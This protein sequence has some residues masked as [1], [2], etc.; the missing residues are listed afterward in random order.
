MFIEKFLNNGVPYLRLVENYRTTDSNGVKRVRKKTILN[1]GSLSKFDDGQPNFYERLKTSFKAGNPLI[2]VLKPYCPTSPV[3]ERYNLTFIEG[4]SYCF[5][6]PKLYS[7]CLI[8]QYLNALG[9]ISTIA[10]CKKQTNIQFD[11]AGFVRLLIYGRILKP[12]SKIGTARQNNDYYNEIVKDMYEYNIYDT[13][14]FISSYK[15]KF[16]RTLNKNLKEKFNRTT[17]LIYYDVTNFYF[18][19]ERP[20]EDYEDEDGDINVGLRKN[21]VSKEERKLPIVQ[22]GLF[23]DEQG[24]PIS[25]ETFPGNTLD[26]LTVIK[27]LEKSVDDLGLPRFI[28]VGDRGM[29][30]G[31]NAAYLSQHNN[32]YIMSK[33]IQKSSK[34][35]KDWMLDQNGFTFIG[36]DFKY[37]SRIVQRKVK[38]EDGTYTISE[39]MIVYWSK[40]FY[41][42]MMA[43][44][45]SLIETLEKIKENPKNFRLES[46]KSKQLKSFLK[47]EYINE[48][49]GEVIDGKDLSAAIDYDK[50]NKYKS[51]FGYYQ[52]VTSELEMADQKVIDTYHGLSQIERQFQTMKS[53][54][55]TRPLYVRNPKHIEAHLFV[56]MVSLIIVRLIQNKIIVLKGRNNDLDWETGLSSDKIQ[57]ALNKW[58]VDCLD[59]TYYRFNGLKD[60]NLNLILEAHGI[61]IPQ[62]LFQKG[63]L[64]KIKTEIKL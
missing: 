25:I 59:G 30:Q 52:I 24:V 50:V 64:R 2:P 15:R 46:I 41:N 17:N 20:D 53:T 58:Q 5:G 34:N 26:H 55:S 3:R 35:D 18:E 29:Y 49:T 60:P 56:C 32:G 9:I 37:K 11:V 8:E 27:T 38:T 6:E 47:K 54:L 40:N 36:N 14:D 43:E 4:D 16:V 22:M 28:F 12:T 61:N 42:R 44:N 31:N 1:I 33:S 13:L 7:H 62:K 63:E 57:E 45:K 51:Q 10:Q 39:K 19:I 48:K 21:G 23:M